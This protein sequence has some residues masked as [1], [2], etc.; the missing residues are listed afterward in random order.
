MVKKAMIEGPDSPDDINPSSDKIH[1]QRGETGLWMGYADPKLIIDSANRL[2]AMAY[3]KENYKGLVYWH[4]TDKQ[5][6]YF[7]QGDAPDM[8]TAKEQATNV[9]LKQPKEL[10]MAPDLITGSPIEETDILQPLL[11]KESNKNIPTKKSE[12]TTAMTVFGGMR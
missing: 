7:A 3:R 9:W 2:V 5:R 11:D 10:A 12:Q 1:W 4:V 6:G 8:K